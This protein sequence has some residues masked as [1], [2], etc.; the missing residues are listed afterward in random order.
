MTADE[1]ARSNHSKFPFHNGGG[2]YDFGRWCDADRS[3]DAVP[4]AQ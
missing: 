4:N 3:A 1:P 2:G